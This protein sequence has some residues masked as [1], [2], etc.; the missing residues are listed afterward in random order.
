MV[1]LGRFDIGAERNARRH[2][3]VIAGADAEQHAAVVF[4]ERLDLVI[5]DDGFDARTGNAVGALWAKAGVAAR[6]AAEAAVAKRIFFTTILHVLAPFQ[7]DEDEGVVDGIAQNT[8]NPP[9]SL[10]LPSGPA[11]PF[12]HCGERHLSLQ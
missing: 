4:A 1:R 11:A 9:I 8:A 5:A 6:N 3:E 2:G 10:M 12:A 7:D